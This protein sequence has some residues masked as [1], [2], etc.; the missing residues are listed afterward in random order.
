MAEQKPSAPP[1]GELDQ[2][3]EPPESPNDSLQ[4]AA[5]EPA[6]SAR[7]KG[8]P[9]EGSPRENDRVGVV[10]DPDFVGRHD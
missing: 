5:A 4:P 8:H 1:A 6:G 7:A 9:V 2:S 3:H 10:S